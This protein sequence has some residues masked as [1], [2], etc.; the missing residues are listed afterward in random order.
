MIKIKKCFVFNNSFS[1]IFKNETRHTSYCNIHIKE[2]NQLKEAAER[3]KKG[4]RSKN[5]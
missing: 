4:K 2:K 3:K 1:K 5:R